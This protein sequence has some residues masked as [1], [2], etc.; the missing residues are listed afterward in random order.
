MN[1]H[2]WVKMDHGPVFNRM[3]PATFALLLP[4]AVIFGAFRVLV[5]DGFFTEIASVARNMGKAIVTGNNGG[6]D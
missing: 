5:E 6:W 2:Q 4:L 3:K 1:L